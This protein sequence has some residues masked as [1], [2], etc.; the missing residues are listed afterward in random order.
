MASGCGG[1]WREF[2]QVWLMSDCM[3]LGLAALQS[4][5]ES[6]VRCMRH[7]I[8]LAAY[9]NDIDVLDGAFLCQDTSDMRARDAPM[10]ACATAVQCMRGIE[11]VPRMLEKRN[12]L[13]FLCVR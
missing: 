8:L 4:A 12:T 13:R 7:N 5:H 11:L 1:V 3:Q 10:Q 9:I 6:D 2:D